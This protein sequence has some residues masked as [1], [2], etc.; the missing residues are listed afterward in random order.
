MS[1]INLNEG[2]GV[3]V[4]HSG[5]GHVQEFTNHPQVTFIHCN[6]NT[7]EGYE[8]KIPL[9]TR[10]VI[11]T[12]GLP[13]FPYA[14]IMAYVRRKNIIYLIRKSTPHIYETL[15]SLFPPARKAT[16]EQVKETQSRGKLEVLFPLIDF[17]KSNI[18]NAKIL[19][20]R[21]VELKIATTEGSLAQYVSKLR[22][23]QSGT[24]VV[25]SARPKLDISVEILD[26]A[27]KGLTDM[28]EF[29]IATVEENRLLRAK[30]DKLKKAMEEL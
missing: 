25:K 10:A 26:E 17:N 22:R 13:Q 23:Q 11:L 1:D 12:D 14:W 27:I 19:M 18:E 20:R 3:V 29:L 6:E 28:R 24:A 5:N 16:L 2:G 4:F 9:N 30:Y 21:A 8:S 15:K 7:A